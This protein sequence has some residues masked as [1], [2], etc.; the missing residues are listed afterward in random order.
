ML[1]RP[2]RSTLF[3]YTTLFRSTVWSSTQV[4]FAVRTAVASVLSMA[5]EH[6][7]VIVPEVGGGFGVKGH[8]YP[9]DI[10]VPA[11]ARHLRRPV[12]WIET[13]REHLLSAAPDRD[14]E[15][16]ARLGVRA[17]GTIVALETEFT[18]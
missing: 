15:H 3:P 11:V 17:D 8:V 7:R 14:Q 2:P 12:K 6:V 18:R 10:L 5:E 1:R 13:R 16:R 4:P 9:E